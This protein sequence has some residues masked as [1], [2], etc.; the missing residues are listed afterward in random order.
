MVLYISALDHSRNTTQE[1]HSDAQA[2]PK[3]SVLLGVLKS[4]ESELTKRELLGLKRHN[5]IP[6]WFLAETERNI[7]LWRNGKSLDDQRD[8]TFWIDVGALITKR[9][10]Q[11]KKPHGFNPF[12]N[13]LG[14]SLPMDARSIEE[15]VEYLETFEDLSET[16]LRQAE[17][18]SHASETIRIELSHGIDTRTAVVLPGEP[19]RKSV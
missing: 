11:L 16:I 1:L 9:R 12:I 18:L 3:G 19:I 8:Y 13:P 17:A 2:L 10:E 6:L 15:E 7:F 5:A 14:G 4:V